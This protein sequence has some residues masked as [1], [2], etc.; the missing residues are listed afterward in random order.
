MAIEIS[1]ELV[2][3]SFN[4]V[5]AAGIWYKLGRVEAIIGM[6]PV[7]QHHTD[8]KTTPEI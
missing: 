6:C 5:M 3:I 1:L 4:T 2:V 7:C 8:K